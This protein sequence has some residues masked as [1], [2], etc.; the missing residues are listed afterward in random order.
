MIAAVD[1]VLEV[2]NL[3]SNVESLLGCREEFVCEGVGNAVEWEHRIGGAR[4]SNV[5]V[6]MVTVSI[7]VDVLDGSSM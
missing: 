7:R 5:S 3:N 4:F 6:N 1:G 2:E